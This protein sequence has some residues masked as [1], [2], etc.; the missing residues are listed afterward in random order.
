[1]HDQGGD[2][3]VVATHDIE[4]L[5][6]RGLVVLGG[7]TFLGIV[8]YDHLGITEWQAHTLGFAHD[9]D[10][11]IDV[12]RVTVAGV[13]LCVLGNVGTGIEGLMAYQHT[14]TERFPREF[15]GGLQTTGV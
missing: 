13:V 6:E 3:A 9:A 5:V 10:A 14:V 12:G 7:G 11:P 8:G 15:C 4:A 2:E 1:M